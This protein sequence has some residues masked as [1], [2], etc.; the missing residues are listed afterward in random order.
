MKKVRSVPN[1][2]KLSHTS[3]EGSDQTNTGCR[4]VGSSGWLGVRRKTGSVIR[5]F[6][7]LFRSK[8]KM[9]SS[10]STEELRSLYKRL[11]EF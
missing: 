9:V 5:R 11:G 6:L 4:G 10:L 7:N 1:A 3:K 2:P 8:P